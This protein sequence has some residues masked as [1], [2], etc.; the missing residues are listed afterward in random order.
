MK[1]A[2]SGDIIGLDH[3]AVLKTIELYATNGDAKKI[4]EGVLMCHR[5]EQKLAKEKG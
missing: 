4:F 1:V 3:V 2:P 5:I